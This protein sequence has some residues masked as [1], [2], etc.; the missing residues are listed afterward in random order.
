MDK[1]IEHQ[2]VKAN[3]ASL[4][5]A[6][7]GTGPTL[8]LLHGWPE[9]WLTWE[10]V[11]RRL[12]DRFEL[13]APDLRGFGDS[14]K[15]DGPWGGAEHAADLLALLDALG[16]RG[17][18]GLVGHDVGGAVM[19]AMARLAP[20]RFSGLFFFDFFYPGIGSRAGA[21]DRLGEIWYQSFH[22][23]PFAPA[24][25]GATRE[26]CAL[27]IGHFL[28]RWA[29]RKDAFD[30]VF[31]TWVDNFMK[32]GNL[33]GGFAYYQAAQAARLAVMRGEAPAL[34]PIGVP[35]CV[36]WAEHDA[37]FPAAFAD[38][39]GETFADLDFSLLPGVGHYPHREDPDLAAREIAG[40][41]G[42]IG[43]RAP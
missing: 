11:M 31:E 2:T 19:Q 43:L 4:H 26:T 22:Q 23:M 6:R 38:R 37:I 32:P 30:D 17:P 1:M 41:F 8:L 16:R 9:F 35:T 40:F 14:D 36:R 3:G 24:L 34:P 29:H 28:R 5:V 27:Y 25:V 42:R 21:P 10:P 15:P 12:A 13:I 20:E 33:A 18:V 7:A 39:L